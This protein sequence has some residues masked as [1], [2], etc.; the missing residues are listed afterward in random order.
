VAH[1]WQLSCRC[2]ETGAIV[3]FASGQI[4]AMV[5]GRIIL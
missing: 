3:G 2:P 1:V 5:S 4:P